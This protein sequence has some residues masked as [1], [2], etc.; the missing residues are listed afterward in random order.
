MTAGSGNLTVQSTQT[1]HPAVTGPNALQRF[2]TLSGVGI[3]TD[4]TFNYLAS[5]VQVTPPVTEDDYKVFKYNGTIF[6]NMGG[7][8][9]SG[10]HKATVTGISSFSD[11]TLAD[12]GSVDTAQP[13]PTYVVNTTNDVNDGFCSIEHCSLREAITVAN[14]NADTTT[15]NFDST[16]FASPGP[17]TINFDRRAARPH[18]QHEH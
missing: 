13:G 9:D 4:V 3:T 14:S 7:T 11:W 2:W 17:Y 12:P 6:V 8:I 18:H 10:N 16:E 15:I 5:D 1:E